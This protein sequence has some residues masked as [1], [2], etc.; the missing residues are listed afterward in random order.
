M[1]TSKH[2]D[3]VLGETEL[4]RWQDK[5]M[6][7]RPGPQLRPPTIRDDV[8]EA[9]YTALL[10]NR[11][12]EVAYRGRAR[13]RPTTIELNPLGIVV[14]AGD[15]LPGGNVLGLRGHSPLCAASHE[16]AEVAGRACQGTGGIPARGPRRRRRP[17][18]L[19]PEHR[20][21]G[22]QGTVRCR[23]GDPSDG[24][25]SRGGPSGDGAGGWSDSD[26]GHGCRHRRPALV[27]VELRVVGGGSQSC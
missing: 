5:A 12:L 16:R 19:S 8:Q 25:P 13:T 27:A 17:L 7:I 20:Q 2:A 26:R 4:G 10:D 15:R 21:V 3:R 22:A 11:R 18:L 23:C 1:R 6:I 24:K 9:V 14:R